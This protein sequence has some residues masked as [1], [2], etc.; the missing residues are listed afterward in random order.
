LIFVDRKEWMFGALLR[1]AGFCLLVVAPFQV[2]AEE[3][4]TNK[5]ITI[6]TYDYLPDIEVNNGFLH[7]RGIDYLT[8]V[9]EGA[10][11]KPI[12]QVVPR[13]RLAQHLENNEVD[14]AFPIYEEEL[15]S[16]RK[17]SIRP[18]LF[19]TPGLCFRKEKFIP[20]LSVV[21]RWD[22]LDI[23]YAGGIEI[24]PFLRKNNAR[25]KPVYGTNIQ[26]RLIKMVA[27]QRAD[28]AYVANARSVYNVNSRF[29]HLIACSNFY[30]HANPIHI[31]LSSQ[32]D[33]GVMAALRKSHDELLHY[34]EFMAQDDTRVHLPAEI[35]QE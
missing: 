27:S 33:Y 6:G 29:Y 13:K 26:G 11:Y 32:L 3:R 16:A 24:I 8:K 10:G 31:A 21:D 20:F 28:A 19:E 35:R 5:T 7:G 34:E 4:L 25:L 30:G 9:V 23:I 22:Q 2:L 14:M 12:Y 18:V 1:L 17:M 15:L